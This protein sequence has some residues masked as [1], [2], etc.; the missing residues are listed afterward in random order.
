MNKLLLE[1]VN[2]FETNVNK[3]YL[4]TESAKLHRETIDYLQSTLDELQ[5]E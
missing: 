1:A 5:D 4:K 2:S 3:L